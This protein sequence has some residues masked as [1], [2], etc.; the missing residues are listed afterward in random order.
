MRLIAVLLLAAVPCAWAQDAGQAPGDVPLARQSA[1]AHADGLLAEGR[2]AEAIREY[3]RHLEGSPRDARALLMRGVAEQNSGMHSDAMSSFFAVLQEI[4]EQR[5]ALVGLAAG[6]G[7]LGEYGQALG[8][9]E[10]ALASSPSSAIILNYAERM[11]ATVAK[12]PHDPVPKPDWV[13]MSEPPDPGARWLAEAAGRWGSGAMADYEFAPYVAYMEDAGMLEIARDAGRTSIPHWARGNGALWASGQITAGEFAAGIQYMSEAGVADIDVPRSAAEREERGA[14]QAA[15]FA[16]Y[17]RAVESEA[18][19]AKRYVEFPNPSP[20]VIKKFMRD[21]AKWNF[22]QEI[23]A[24][25]ASFPGPEVARGS[26]QTVVTYRIYV[27][28]QPHGLPLDHIPT[29]LEAAAYWEGRELSEGGRD[30]RVE[31]ELNPSKDGASVWVTWVV[32]ELGQGVLGHAHIGKGVVEVALGDYGCDG[33]FQ[34]YDVGSVGLVMRHE[35]GHSIGLGHSEDKSDIMY[36]TLRPAYA[37]CILG[38]FGRPAH[39]P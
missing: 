6:M 21:R 12:Y 30:A 32:R 29:L 15:E 36:P 19:S 39:Q 33:S 2:Y 3:D 9:L 5:R 25:S 31:F 18:S 26:G 10:R 7:N 8:Y 4:P 17:V 27:N 35:L 38:D 22:D 28:E 16:R 11:E 24:S 1:T 34:L 13:S 23:A 37:Y 14:R 20:D